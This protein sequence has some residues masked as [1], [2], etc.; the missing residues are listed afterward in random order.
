MEA[1]FSAEYKYAWA[2]AMALALFLP[3]RQFIWVMQVR[4]AIRQG[5]E[6]SV[7]KA[8]Q[9]RLKRRAGITSAL[10]SLFFSFGYMSVLFAK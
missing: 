6:D 5:G 7:D 4:R 3:V 8:E 2:A 1:L 10:L 9:D